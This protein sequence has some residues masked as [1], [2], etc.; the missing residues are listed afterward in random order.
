MRF[1]YLAKNRSNCYG[2]CDQYFCSRH[3]SSHYENY[4]FSR[5]FR[6]TKDDDTTTE[7]YNNSSP[8]I[9][10][11]GSSSTLNIQWGD[12][13][14]AL[15]SDATCAGIKTAKLRIGVDAITDAVNYPF[16][17]SKLVAGTDDFITVNFTISD[18]SNVAATV[19]VDCETGHTNP[20]IC[21]YIMLLTHFALNL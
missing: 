21:K 7:I 14:I 12:I 2:D 6:I 8:Q 17:D 5:V 19:D 3:C 4:F 9:I 11:I 16:G 10:E 15:G 18:G 13:C 1:L 20:G